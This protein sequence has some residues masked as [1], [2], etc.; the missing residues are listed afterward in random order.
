[1][2]NKI[3]AFIEGSL[4]NG[5]KVRQDE[6]LFASGVLDSLKHL[7]LM[8]FLE[9]EFGISISAR[10]MRIENFDTVDK[11]VALVQRKLAEKSSGTR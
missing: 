2:V 10:D 11:M 8:A 7:K 4:S 5:M 9:K 3:L 6:S 1:M